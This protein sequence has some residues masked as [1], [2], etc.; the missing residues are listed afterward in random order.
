MSPSIYFVPLLRLWK[1]LRSFLIYTFAIF[2]GKDSESKNISDSDNRDICPLLCYA[3]KTQ[4]AGAF[5][6][7]TAGAFIHSCVMLIRFRLEKIQN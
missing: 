4:T 6:I 1:D 5:K 2:A 7:Q 3:D